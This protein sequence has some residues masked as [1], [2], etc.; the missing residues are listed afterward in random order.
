[1]CFQT[2]IPPLVP[3]WRA[4]AQGISLRGTTSTLV[5]HGMFRVVPFSNIN[6]TSSYGYGLYAAA[7][8]TADMTIQDATIPLVDLDR[9]VFTEGTLV[10]KFNKRYG[11]DGGLATYAIEL[12]RTGRVWD[13]LDSP[14]AAS[15][16]NEAV[17]VIKLFKDS[18][19]NRERFK[20]YYDGDCRDEANTM[21]GRR[22]GVPALVATKT[23]YHGEE[24]TV[25]YGAPYW[26]EG[27]SWRKLRA[28]AKKD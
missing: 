19:G 3:L 28:L 2:C 8:Y 12:T 5:N 26:T 16:A 24:I 15:Y 25:P 10:R 21:F 22:K 20:I 9:V 7:E 27:C 13:A 17:N 14:V 11:R 23:I 1:M 6:K 4:S 18:R